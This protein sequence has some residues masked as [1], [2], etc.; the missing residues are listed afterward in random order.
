MDVIKKV[1]SGKKMSVKILMSIFITAVAVVMV[2]ATGVGVV[3]AANPSTRVIVAQGADATTLDPHM[4]R[5][6]TTSN[7]LSHIYDTLIMRGS[8]MSLQPLLAESWTYINDTTLEIH[9]KKGIRFHNGE[10]LTAET[11][12]YNFD[13]VTGKLPGARLTKVSYRYVNVKD[14]EVVDKYALRVHLF[15]PD[16]LFLGQLSELPIVPKEYTEKHGFEILDTRPVGTGPYKLK[17]WEH[18]SQIVLT[19]NPDY[20]RGSAAIEE[21]VFR[22]LPDPMTRVAELMTGGVDIIVNLPPDSI[23]QVEMQSNL[24]VKTVPSARVAYV[25]FN[26]LETPQFADVRVRRALN[27][28][29]DVEAIIKYVYGGHGMRISTMAPP[30]FT[31]YDP[32]D[33]VYSY[34][35]EKARALLREAGYGDGF[36]VTMLT[37]R[38]RFLNDIL[39]AQ[40][41]ASYLEEVGVHVNINAV[42]F[43]VFAKQTQERRIPEM[44]LAALGTSSFNVLDAMRTIVRSGDQAF[45]W[46]SNPKVDVL[47]DKAAKTIDEEEHEWL[48]QEA[49]D[50]LYED[51]P[52]IYLFALEDIYG[53]NRRVDWQPRSDERIYLYDARILPQ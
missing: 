12:K 46:Y 35:P 40:T 53:V 10:E 44:M 25:W 45:S 48:L 34:D 22:V 5:E 3:Q 11:V 36:T 13:R 21:V 52:F 24:A 29:V 30:Y 4:H 39:L 28:A 43:G 14:S 9:L 47:I 26:M 15:H 42:E 20:F 33:P 23:P 18:E 16:S 50:I 27:Y 2:A 38:G 31:G 17:K 37:T 7:V 41:I 1:F 8:D 51:P 32:K 19:R 49:L 6:T